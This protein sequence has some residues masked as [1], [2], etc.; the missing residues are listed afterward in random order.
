MSGAARADRVRGTCKVR[1]AGPTGGSS[2]SAGA[3]D[4]WS[5]GADPSGTVD[6]HRAASRGVRHPACHGARRSERVTLA[7]V[8]EA[9]LEASR[10]AVEAGGHALDVELP[11]EPVWLY[12]DGARL[13]QVLG[14]LLNN[15]ATYT[16]PNGR[17]TLRASLQTGS[18]VV[19][20]SDT[21]VGIEAGMPQ[22]VFGLL[23]QVDGTLEA[24]SE[25]LG[26]GATFTMRLPRSRVAGA[27]PAA[28]PRIGPIGETT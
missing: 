13:S 1:A 24:A 12:A 14:N 7:A 23:T 18:V 9:A 21:G 4:P 15:A 2:D 10:P 25:G 26:H 20:V 5:R 6:P 17:I 8:V 22:R 27:A 3:G 11:D 28:G 19:A 16:A